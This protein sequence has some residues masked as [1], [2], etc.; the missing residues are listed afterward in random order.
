M[1]KNNILKY[2]AILIS[3]FVISFCIEIFIFNFKL[4]TIDK[5]IKGIHNIKNYTEKISKGK[6]IISF[7]ANDT[8]ANKLKI[9]YDAEEDVRCEI[10]Y[11]TKD[12]YNSNMK[13][14][15]TDVFDNEVNLQVINTNNYISRVKIIIDKNASVSIDRIYIDNTLKINYYRMIFFV[16]SLLSLTIII[17]FFKKGGKTEFIHRYFLIIGLI[18]GTILITCQPSATYYSWDDQVHFKSSL[19]MFQSN[20][21]WNVGEYSM[22]ADTPVGRDSISSIEEQQ[23]QS[24]YLNVDKL[25]NYNTTSSRFISYNKIAYLPL[26]IGYK[27]CKLIKLPFVICFKVGKLM[28]LLVFMLIMSFAIKKAKKGKRLIVVIGLLPSTLFLACQ[29]SY[30]PA[31]I[32]GITLGIV[33][34]FNWFYDKESTVTFNTLLVFLI[35]ILYASFTK[36]IYIPFLALLLFIPHDRF[37]SMKQEMWIKGFGLFILLLVLSTFALP[38]DLASTTTG[39]SRVGNTS[40]SAQYHLIISNPIGYVK[41][42]WDTAVGQFSQKMFGLQTVGG[43]AYMGNVSNNIYILSLALLFFVGITD[44]NKFKLTIHQ[45]LASLICII[46][47]IVFIWTAL[48]LAFTPVGFN[49]INGVQCRYFIPL[50]FPLLICLQPNKLI[51]NINEKHYNIIIFMLMIIMNI[52]S[53]YQLI[54]VYYCF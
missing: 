35:A 53:I 18:M 43:F 16:G 9:Q 42:L 4:L 51:N 19:E 28:N 25:S 27:I 47:I 13:K 41:I 1:K 33:Y 45:K 48:Y 34:L 24:E 49:T 46:G 40:V 7:N 17:H 11:V 21:N 6:K 15:I 37:K 2:I 29:Y 20:I 14:N 31:V 54:I 8:Y 23:N 36:A 22:I 30:D 32:S 44:V 12:Y 5:S 39:D 26:S 3:I 38:S 52:V 50:L 10:E